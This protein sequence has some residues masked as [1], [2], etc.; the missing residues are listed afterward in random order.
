[1]S[2]FY[3]DP[4]EMALDFASMGYYQDAFQALQTVPNKKSADFLY[5]LGTI[6][7]MMGQN[8]SAVETFGRI[9]SMNV[10]N[11]I[12]AQAHSTI[13]DIFLQEGRPYDALNEI[14]RAMEL[15]PE[16]EEHK[17][18]AEE[19]IDDLNSDFGKFLFMTIALTQ[20]ARIGASD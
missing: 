14:N 20:A 18:K 11:Y 2:T 4:L 7:M 17:M 10:D 19:I 3:I 6:Q 12:R 9:S 5:S 16:D 8:E 1:M 13:S 15:D